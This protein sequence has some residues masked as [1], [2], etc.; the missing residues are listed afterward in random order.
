MAF[1]EDVRNRTYIAG[2]D[3]SAKQFHFVTLA[4]DGQIDPT[5][6]GARADGV[7]LNKPAAAGEA[8]TVCYD[9]RVT[10][11]AG[12]TV[13]LGANV[14]SNAAGAAVVATT[15]EVILGKALEAAVSGQ[16]FTIELSRAES[17]V[18]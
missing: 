16:V 17:V 13:T 9:G 14:A 12:G 3:L 11:V 6:D 7:L 8:A 2:Q 18:A 4:T 1:M 10:V 15:G 5:G